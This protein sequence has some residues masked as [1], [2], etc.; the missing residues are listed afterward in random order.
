MAAEAIFELFDG[1]L[2]R[3]ISPAGQ[4]IDQLV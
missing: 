3:A 1:A 2:M 4:V